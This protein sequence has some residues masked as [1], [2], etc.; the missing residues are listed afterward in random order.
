MHG[1]YRRIK[2]YSWSVNSVRP[3]TACH[4]ADQGGI[5]IF[6]LVI[7]L[8]KTYLI[9]PLSVTKTAA[10]ACVSLLTL[11]FSP[12]PKN[13]TTIYRK[14]ILMAASRL[15]HTVRMLPVWPYTTRQFSKRRSVQITNGRITKSL[16][17]RDR[18]KMRRCI[19]KVIL[20]WKWS[21]R[22]AWRKELIPSLMRKT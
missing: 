5:F 17:F 8:L 4:L 6:A 9:L 13:L 20:Y 18:I 11:L 22:A 19:M 10:N 1:G 2:R 3:T 14:T 7:P 12:A 21:P 15:P 16:L